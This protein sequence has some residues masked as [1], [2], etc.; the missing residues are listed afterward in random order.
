MNPKT[1]VLGLIAIACLSTANAKKQFSGDWITSVEGGIGE[2]YT[3]NASNSIFGVMCI[4]NCVFYVDFQKDCVDGE[5]YSS[6]VSSDAGAKTFEMKCFHLGKRRFLSINDFDA[7][8][9]ITLKSKSIGFA[10]ALPDSKFHVSRF[11]LNGSK[12]AQLKVLK[13]MIDTKQFKDTRM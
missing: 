12:D 10:I 7:I 6:L 13:K 2:A 5:E 4:E 8:Q 11:S 3:Y 9:T 1:L